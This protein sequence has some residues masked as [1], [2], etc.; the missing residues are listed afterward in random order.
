MVLNCRK[1][2]TTVYSKD[3]QAFLM[4][5]VSKS[6]DL[7]TVG[8][9]LQKLLLSFRL[10]LLIVETQVMEFQIRKHKISFSLNV[11]AWKLKE[12]THDFNHDFN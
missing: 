12:I 2:P 3:F 7:S 6:L 11:W 4:P 10:R 9:T 8:S 1:W 5:K